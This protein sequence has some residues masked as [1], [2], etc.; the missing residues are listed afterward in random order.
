MPT[1]LKTSGWLLLLALL[2]ACAALGLGRAESPEPLALWRDAHAALDSASFERAIQS[3]DRLAREHPSTE[4]GREAL[5]YLGTL[6]LD[7]RNAAWDSQQAEDA[8]RRYLALDPQEY[9]IQRRPEARTMYEL[10]QQLNL[11]PD[12]RSLAALQP[13][14]RPAPVRPTRVV[15]QSRF[16]DV[17]GQLRSAASERDQLRAERDRLRDT[18]KQ[19]DEELERIRRTLTG[20]GRRQ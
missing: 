8:L 9:A 13:G 2:P 20:T 19:K 7:P 12:E 6:Y 4:P 18:I 16:E 1:Y 17:Q 15:P 10:A 11:P 14:T 5:F 3:F